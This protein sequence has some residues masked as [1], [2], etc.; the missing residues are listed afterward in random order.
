MAALRPEILLLCSSCAE[1][2]VC[3]NGHGG[4]RSQIDPTVNSVT[5]FANQWPQQDDNFVFLFD[6]VDIINVS[7]DPGTRWLALCITMY[8]ACKREAPA[9]HLST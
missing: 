6:R 3:C 4:A 8:Y 9:L 1:T 7:R 5:N 2:A